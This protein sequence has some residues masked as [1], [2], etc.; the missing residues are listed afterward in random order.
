MP[1]KTN[2]R[3]YRM[4]QP[5]TVPSE[6]DANKKRFDSAYYVE[7]YA[8]TFD[9]PYL[10]FSWDGVDYYEQIDR[11]A[12]EGADMSD[13]IMQY[14]HEGR[15]YARNGNG[16]L[17][18]E[19]DDHGLF[20]YADLSKTE[21]AKDL[22]EDIAAG[23]ITEMSWAFTEWERSFDKSNNTWTVRK[24]RKV[25][26][27]SAVSRGANP[28]TEISARTLLDGVI[29]QQERESLKRRLQILKIKTLLEEIKR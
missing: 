2:E 6:E 14:N 26:D 9:Q 18:M 3:I 17:G 29:E 13:V 11:K 21:R 5:F 28:A 24:V 4:M 8:T 23:M 10:L 25:Y 16:T 22:Y 12:F 20:I 19:T 7:G 27:V 1:V 15:V